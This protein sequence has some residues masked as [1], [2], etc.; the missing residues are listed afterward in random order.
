MRSLGRFAVID[1]IR[2]LLAIVGSITVAY[3]F[4]ACL[5]DMFKHVPDHLP[6]PR[7]DSRDTQRRWGRIQ[8]R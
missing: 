3:L 8:G 1:L 4:G 2:D 6:P 5:A 7:E